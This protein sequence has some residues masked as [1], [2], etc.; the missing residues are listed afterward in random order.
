[1]GT[2][3]LRRFV[4]GG[5][6]V[7]TCLSIACGSGG[8]SGGTE[9]PPPGALSALAVEGGATPAGGTYGAFGPT[10]LLATANGGWVAFVAYVVGGSTSRGLFV[11]RPSGQVVLAYAIG[12]TVPGTNGAT[13]TIA[14]FERIWMRPGGV[15]LALVGISGGSVEGVVTAVVPSSG[16]VGT[17]RTAIH[18]GRALPQGFSTS[19][20]GT[21]TAIDGDH[22]EVS[23]AGNVYFVGTGTGDVPLRGIW[24]VRRDG[25]DLT[26]VAV[27]DDPVVDPPSNTLGTLGH[28][29]SGLGIDGT[30]EVVS[31][32]CDVPEMAVEALLVTRGTGFYVLAR[33]GNS[34]PSAPGRLFDDV[35]DGGPIV[36]RL[37]PLGIGDVTWEGSLTEPAPDRGIFTRDVTILVT[38]ELLL[39]VDL[40]N[41][42]LPLEVI[43]DTNG[44]FASDCRIF[45]GQDDP[46]R[47]PIE[48][49]VDGGSTDRVF[50]SVFHRDV[51]T[52]VFREGSLAPGTQNSFAD[53]YPSLTL[54]GYDTQSRDSS[55][56]FT[57]VLVDASTGLWWP[58]FGASFFLVAAEGDPAPGTGGGDF[59]SFATPSAV[60]AALGFIAFRA[61]IVGGT[62]ATA[63]FRQT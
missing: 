2:S 63:L 11:A 8:G 26:A 40:N 54:E 7:A 13:G 19:L 4:V 28:E 62:T 49:V 25:S 16:A 15:V 12:A 10:M 20:P 55:F 43:A 30:G 37:D 17:K 58:V 14:E 46:L 21:L 27:E 59:G 29:F 1:M 41:V 6:L 32:A 60:S 50:L 18:R 45:E 42:V 61:A 34:P 9:A 51:L 33:D 31:F 5:A 24:A 3:V 52:E 47:W 38:G 53:T 22:V 48:V 36:V 23:D 39:G 56:A 44:G 57:A 35:H